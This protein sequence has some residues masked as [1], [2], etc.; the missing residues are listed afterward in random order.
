MNVDTLNNLDEQDKSLLEEIEKLADSSSYQK[1]FID[2]SQPIDEL[3]QKLIEKKGSISF[4]SLSDKERYAAEI[5][6]SS[7]EIN[8]Y[9]NELGKLDCEYIKPNLMRRILSLSF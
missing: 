9:R 2:T 6:A 8:L 5:L 1:N 4:Y 3:L 7:G